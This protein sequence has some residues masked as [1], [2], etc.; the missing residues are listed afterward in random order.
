LPPPHVPQ[1]QFVH[2]GLTTSTDITGPGYLLEE[3]INSLFIKY[4]LNNS[5]KPM[6]NLEAAKLQ[7]STFLCFAQHV[8]Y[9]LSG[10]QVI[11]SDFQGVSAS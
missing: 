7:I 2:Y 3:N 10:G 11:L 4:I 8:Q 5:L 9:H 6:P 1:L